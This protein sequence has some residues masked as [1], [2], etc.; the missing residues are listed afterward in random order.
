MSA[1]ISREAQHLFVHRDN[2][3]LLVFLSSGAEDAVGVSAT[4]VIMASGKSRL[5]PHIGGCSRGQGVSRGYGPQSLLTS[6]SIGEFCVLGLVGRGFCLC[7]KGIGG[8]LN[9]GVAS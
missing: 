3:F 1:F 5:D 4:V 2:A 9:N 8:S 6:R 7:K